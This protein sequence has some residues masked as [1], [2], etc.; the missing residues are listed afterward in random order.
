M[1]EKNLILSLILLLLVSSLYAQA[2]EK[3]NY[4]GVARDNSGNLLT[5]QNISLRFTIHSGSLNGPS[6]YAET[7]SLLTDMYG[8]FQT[9]IGSGSIIS[10]NFAAIDWGINSFFLQI[11][12]DPTGGSNYLNM[13]TSQLVSVPY[14]LHAK[15]A[16]NCMK[17]NLNS[18]SVFNG[19]ALSTWTDLDLSS[20]VGNNYA[21]VI[22]K[23]RNFTNQEF[24]AHFRQNGDTD[25]QLIGA[26]VNTRVVLGNNGVGQVYVITDENGIVEWKS[27]NTGASEIE[28]I[29]F[30]K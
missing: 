7:H 9:T 8:S 23:V 5:S 17:L 26:D 11:E 22:L 12:L 6:V 16:E 27:N 13:G 15:E 28:V 25:D 29:A 10:G 2:P 24:I 3:I 18:G 1:M 21:M 14:A 20:V 30:F 4:Q 19:D